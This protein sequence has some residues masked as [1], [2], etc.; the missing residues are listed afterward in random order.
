MK[1]EETVPRS[2]L[3]KPLGELT[4]EDISQLT[5]EDCRRYLKEKGMRRPSWNKSQ[6]IQQVISLK[7]L[8]ETRTESGD[9][10][11]R[12]KTSFIPEPENPPHVESGSEIESVSDRSKG[13]QQSAVSG[14]VSSHLPATGS[15]PFAVEYTGISPRAA[16]EGPPVG[17]M[18]IFYAGKVNVYEGVPPDKARLIMQIAGS[19]NSCPPYETAAGYQGTRPFPSRLPSETVRTGPPASPPL[20]RVINSPT[21]QQQAGKM[22]QLYRENT[23][24]RKMSREIDCE[25]P[26]NRQ[27]SLQRYL[28][29]RKDRF[30]NKRKPGGSSSSSLEVYVNQQLRG[31]QTSNGQSRSGTCSPT[32]PRPPHT[33]AR[34]S[35][36]ENQAKNICLSV[37]LNDDGKVG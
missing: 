23:D 19:P 3:D 37:D 26:T 15:G 2:P 14:D 9:A 33:P 29:K 18:T 5:R 21:S 36:V 20:V 24:E 7:T 1:P 25:G 28:E 11:I 13:P 10:G 34:C 4:E 35:S 17:Q 8:L 32:Q 6:A 30:K 31:G 27:A 16:T 12:Q 22:P